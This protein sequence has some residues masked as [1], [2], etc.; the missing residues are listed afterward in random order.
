MIGKNAIKKDILILIFVSGLLFLLGNNIISLT[1]DNE[2]FYAQTAKEMSEHNSWMTPYLFGHPQF[3]KP[4]FT[5]WLLR[6]SFLIFGISSFGARFFPAVFGIL[7]VV[8]IYYLGLL[9]F[10]DR[11]KAFISSIVLMTCGMY[12]GLAKSLFTDMFFSVFIAI[13]LMLFF[14]AY[15]LRDKKT[16]AFIFA[17]VS[18]GLA[19]L[20]KGPLG[21][22]IPSLV[23]FIFLLIKKDLKFLCCRETLW[24]VLILLV[25]IAPWY[26]LMIHK[27]GN[28]FINEFILNDNLRRAVE[29]QH[30]GHDVWYYYPSLI[31]S[32]MLPW[33][34]FVVG[35]LIFVYRG[36]RQKENTFYMFLLCWIVPVFI[37]FQVAHSKVSSYIF[38]LF[39]PLALLAGGFIRDI[40][41]NAKYKVILYA[42]LSIVSF[43]VLA[44]PIALFFSSK[45][46][47]VYIVDK[48]GVYFLVT[49]FSLLAAI[50]LFCIYKK[51]PSA[52]IY[53]IAFSVPIFLLSLPF[54]YKNFERYVS[55]KEASEYLLQIANINNTIVCSKTFVRGVKYYTDK[56]VAVID[57]TGKKF[58][59]PHPIPFLNTE[60]EARDFF[61]KQKITYCV[62]NKSLVKDIK[63]IAKNDFNVTVLKVAGN[64]YIIKVERL[65]NLFA[66]R[67]GL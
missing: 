19:V 66:Q 2:V 42:I 25:T 46:Y 9:G 64:E 36:L 6:L 1:N 67:K 48:T 10:R 31:M 12:I 15:T 41:T 63:K 54:T 34:L 18:M 55:S 50:I 39:P 58:F 26:A 29:A 61:F 38:P 7:G 53:M 56:D 33:S 8:A 20:T 59:S 28:T 60:E 3:E 22:I 51:K 32:G 5:Y 52:A 45:Q 57:I 16:I 30:S 65:G 27:Y 47:A 4:I 35:A 24:S 23:V 43:F 62:V 44:I 13:S 17:A 11:L 40:L 21:I 14:L 49:A 37:I